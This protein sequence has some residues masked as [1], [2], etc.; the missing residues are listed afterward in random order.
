MD[1]Q[2]QGFGTYIHF[3]N[4]YF[5]K[6]SKQL[7]DADLEKLIDMAEKAKSNVFLETIITPSNTSAILQAIQQ[8]AVSGQPRYMMLFEFA[9]GDREWLTQVIENYKLLG[10]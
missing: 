2:P 1:F 10:C 9:K 4:K 6:E 3:E 5:S 8:P 7:A